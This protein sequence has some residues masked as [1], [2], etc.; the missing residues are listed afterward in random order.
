MNAHDHL[1][2]L[3]Q[4]R[5]Q[6]F[7]RA[8]GG[9]GIAALSSLLNPSL[10]AKTGDPPESPGKLPKLH[11]PAKAKRVIY[12]HQSG[13]PS[14]IDL[15]DYKPAMQA[16]HGKELPASIRMGQRITG[17]TAGQ[18]AFPIA[19]SQWK[20]QQHGKAGT[21][22]SELLPH[23]GK[24]ADDICLVRSM[25]TEAINHDPAITFIQT[26]SEQPGRPC[27]G[28][29]VTYG[30]GSVN[31]NLPSFVVHLSGLG[32][33]KRSAVVFATLGCGLFAGQLSRCEIPQSGRS[34]PV[35][36]ES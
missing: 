21:W 9:I 32:G 2:A 29:W 36:Q 31:Q 15:L 22:L 27:M 10:F 12:L 7:G 23:H 14:H 28:S 30:I 8:A 3:Q 5:R 11:F 35:H 20:F 24:I 17:M 1:A 13:A 18:K 16:H 33:E 6:F 25:H 19:A 34:G 26:G 4:T